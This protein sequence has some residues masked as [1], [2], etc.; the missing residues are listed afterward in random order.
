MKLAILGPKGTFSDNAGIEYLINNNLSY[1]KV[2]YQTIDDVIFSIGNECDRGIVPIENTLDG[3][4]QRTLDLLLETKTHIIGE[5]SVPVQ[6][7]LVANV[8]KIEDIKD[9]YVQFKSNG[10]CRT[11]INSLNNI[12]I[13]TTNSNMESFNLAKKGAYGSSAIIP[14]HMLH[15]SD[16]DFKIDNVT[17]AKKNFTRFVIIEKGEY[18]N[19]SFGEKD[20]KSSVFI[21]PK[22]DKPGMLFDILKSFA[23]NNINLV[24]IMSRPQ[25]TDMGKYNFYI[26]INGASHKKEVI[27]NTIDEINEK[28]GVKILGMYSL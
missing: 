28:Y 6:F 21:T 3:Y 16:A 12:N 13:I 14:R 8:E 1:E 4:V 23:K 5:I 19:I 22:E 27:L 2:Y 26:E 15:K 25:K 17:D 18:K 10:Q 24:S 11:F 20:I 7:S 9:L